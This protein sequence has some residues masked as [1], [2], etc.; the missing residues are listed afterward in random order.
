MAILGLLIL[1]AATVVGVEVGLG[2]RTTTG[3]EVF[4]T[5]FTMPVYVVFVLGALLMALAI[6]GTFRI[7]GAF[8]RRRS[9]RTAARHRVRE[10]E[11]ADRLTTTDSTN[12]ELVE[13][14]DRLRAE[15]A[16]ERRSAATLGGVAVPPGAGNVAYGDQVSDAVRSATISETGRFEPYPNDAVRTNDGVVDLDATRDH[17]REDDK[18]RVVG[19]FRGKH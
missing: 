16:A 1:A 2:N 17:D 8:Q 19:R 4:G 14:N 5:G 7:T 15:L 9:Y 6:L 12:A 11:T 13:E 10:E 3:L 18:A